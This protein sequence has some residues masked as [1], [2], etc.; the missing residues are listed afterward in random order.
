M[1]HGD[2]VGKREDAVDV[3]LDENHAMRPG[4]HLDERG[5]TG[6]VGLSEAG[7]R[8]VK[9]QELRVGRQRDTDLEQ[10]PLT[11]REV[12]AD[13]RRTVG[14]A[15]RIEDRPDLGVSDVVNVG[16][17]P[18]IV[19]PRALRLDGEAD[20]LEGGEIG[21]DADDLERPGKTE[22]GTLVHRPAA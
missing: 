19:G 9:Q 12:R 5:D 22:T 20:V 16:V 8:L 21:E 11:V 6:S 17:A 13:L 3:V 7:K 14:E 4:Q 10:P 1:Q 15:D 2:A 18:E